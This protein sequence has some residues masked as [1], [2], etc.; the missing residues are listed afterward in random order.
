[1]QLLREEN[2][3]LSALAAYPWVFLPSGPFNMN[4]EDSLEGV[5]ARLEEGSVVCDSIAMLKALVM[6]SDHLGLMPAHAIEN[7]L[8]DRRLQQLP[9]TIPAFSRSIAVFMRE[10]HEL[11]KPSRDLIDAIQSRGIALAGGGV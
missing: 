1:H 7:E 9:L 11:D 3:K 4:Y 5:G 2:L 8:E 6:C 10:E